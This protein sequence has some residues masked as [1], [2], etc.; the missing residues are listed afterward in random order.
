LVGRNRFEEALDCF[1]SLKADDRLD[2]MLQFW[3]ATAAARLG[4]FT[5]AITLATSAEAGFGERGQCPEDMR[6][7]NLLGALALE[8]GD[9]VVAERRFRAVL[10][11]E[12]LPSEPVVLGHA[13]TNLASIMDLR[14]R[15]DAA[16]RLYYDGLRLYQDAGDYRGMAQ[17]YHNLNLVFRNMGMLEAAESVAR[18]AVRTAETAG[19]PSLLALCL[20]GHAE[21]SMERG[22]LAAAGAFLARAQEGARGMGDEM[23]I[24]EVGRVSARYHLREGRTGEAIA[25]AEISRSIANRCGSKLVASECAAL[26][27]IGLGRLG[28]TEEAVERRQEASRGFDHLAAEWL[29]QRYIRAW[30]E[31]AIPDEP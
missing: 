31:A 27:A 28:L 4:R 24:A 12:H 18:Q 10:D 19:E 8:R 2:P 5:I 6:V 14:G 30:N 15:P 16:L 13:I 22:N 25:Q 17:T 9:L 11:R 21:T 1:F 20:S 23:C 3:A 26:S 29:Q 7:L